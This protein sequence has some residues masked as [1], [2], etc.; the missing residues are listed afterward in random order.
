V[1][2]NETTSKG[3]TSASVSRLYSKI[4]ST[5]WISKEIAGL[6]CGRAGAYIAF[7]ARRLTEQKL[8][9]MLLK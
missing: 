5:L 7:S 9:D 4:K 6:Y 2:D 8:P 3:R 1:L